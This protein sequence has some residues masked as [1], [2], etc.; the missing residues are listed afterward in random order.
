M[1]A[2]F[3]ILRATEQELTLID[4]IAAHVKFY[5][6]YLNKATVHVCINKTCKLPTNEIEKM[7]EYLEPARN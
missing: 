3:L 7:I 1:A 6:K 2:A 5:D 4:E